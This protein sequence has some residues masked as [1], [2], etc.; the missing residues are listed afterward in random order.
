[1]SNLSAAITL[2]ASV[3]ALLALHKYE[4]SIYSWT[5]RGYAVCRCAWRAMR[6]I[7]ADGLERCW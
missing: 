6:I 2:M 7:A 4:L 3:W 5:V 1:M